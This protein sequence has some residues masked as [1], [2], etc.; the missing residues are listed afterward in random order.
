MKKYI[1]KIDCDDS[2]GLIYRI[3]DVIF[4]FDLNIATNH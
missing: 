1:L 4:K 3:S 2:K